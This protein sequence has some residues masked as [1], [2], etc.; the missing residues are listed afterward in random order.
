MTFHRSGRN[1]F[2]SCL[3]DPLSLSDEY[4]YFSITLYIARALRLE[5]QNKPK[6][7]LPL[8]S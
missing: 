2:T 1:M 4:I 3:V 5:T 7:N 6:Y 8:I